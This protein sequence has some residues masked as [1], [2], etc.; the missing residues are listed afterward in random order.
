MSE[1]WIVVTA[2]GVMLVVILFLWSSIRRNS[3]FDYRYQKRQE[4]IAREVEENRETI[5]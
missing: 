1:A 5:N 3:D 4:N 2:V